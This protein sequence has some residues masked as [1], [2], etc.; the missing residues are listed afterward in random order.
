MTFDEFIK[1]YDS[2]GIDYDGHFGDQCVDLYRQ[3]VKEVLGFP[4]S[5][6]VTG[7][8]DIWNTYLKDYYDRIEN[9]PSGVPEKGDIV[10]WGDRI[11]PY[12]HVAVFNEGDSR[13]FRA[14]GQNYHT[15][16][17]SH[18][19]SHNYTGV[20]GWLRPK[21]KELNNMD[22]LTQM[23][24]ERGVDIKKPE[25]EVRSKVQEFFDKAKKYDEQESR[26][27]DLEKKVAFAEGEAARYEAELSTSVQNRERLEKEI[28]D[29]KELVSARDTEISNLAKE[30]ENLKVA[31]DPETKI[32]I[33]KDEYE[34]LTKR[35]QLDRYTT[36]EI[37]AEAL[38]RTLR[39]LK[40]K[41]GMDDADWKPKEE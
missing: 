33:S 14:F 18:L 12:G 25:G 16:S 1:K 5:P 21:N 27:A 11:G 3:Y 41:L 26:I 29:L 38:R 37:I 32:I 23:Y 22:W 36:T 17:K 2:K 10:I 31:I 35:K 8:K 30:V 13:S 15:G 6:A 20:L 40:S 34:R 9:T 19:H 39:P 28:R 4:Q 7:A 24:I